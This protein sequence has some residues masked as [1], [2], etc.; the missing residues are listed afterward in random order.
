MQSKLHTIQFFSPHEDQ[1][2]ASP[3]IVIVETLKMMNFNKF[4]KNWNSRTREDWNSWNWE[5]QKASCPLTN[6][7]S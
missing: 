2:A 6:P 1:F 3:R 7:H 5:E 4:P